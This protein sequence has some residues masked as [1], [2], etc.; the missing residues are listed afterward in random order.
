M[1]TFSEVL[2]EIVNES[3]LS[4]YGMAKAVECDRSMLNKVI[5]GDRKINL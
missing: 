1:R 2:R 4:I 3:D 5:S